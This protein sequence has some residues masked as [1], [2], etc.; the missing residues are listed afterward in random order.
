MV[1]LVRDEELIVLYVVSSRQ[2]YTRLGPRTKCIVKGV[3]LRSVSAMKRKGLGA[4]CTAVLV[5]FRLPLMSC[6]GLVKGT[7][8]HCC[9]IPLGLEFEPVDWLDSDSLQ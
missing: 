1:V 3:V 5:K 6:E 8:L 7:A 9:M 2:Q 4:A